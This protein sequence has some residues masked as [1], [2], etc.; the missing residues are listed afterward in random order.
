MIRHYIGETSNITVFF[1]LEHISCCYGHN[2]KWP[3]LSTWIIPEPPPYPLCRTPEKCAGK[4]YCP[5]DP[6]CND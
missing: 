1:G 5:N 3:S 2:E 6:A 4:G